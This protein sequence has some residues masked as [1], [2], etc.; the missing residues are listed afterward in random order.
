MQI[1]ST[2]FSDISIFNHEEELSIFHKLDFT[3][4]TGG[5]ETLKDFF[6]KPFNSIEKIEGTHTILR[7]FLEY[8]DKWPID[9]NNGT[10]VMIEKFLDYP[11]NDVPSKPQSI[12][13]FLFTI[14]NKHD[15]E[16]IRF[17]IKHYADFFRG[18]RDL[19][20]LF[21]HTELPRHV[22]QLLL[23]IQKILKEE[24]LYFLSIQEKSKKLSAK[25]NLY[26]ARYLHERYKYY[27]YELIQIFCKFDAWY[28]MAV[29]VK[30][31]NLCFPDFL[32]VDK[33]F[34][35]ARQLYH[36]LLSQ[37]VSYDITMNREQHFIFLTGANMAGK[38]TFIKSLGACVFLA[39]IG[40]GVPAGR[41]QLSLF[42]GLLSNINVVD[43]IVK[44]ESFFFNEVKRIK[45]TIEKINDGGKW[46]VLIDEL[47]K[48]TNV[49]DAMKCSLA[50]IK[51][52]IKIKNSL[53]VLSTHLYEISEELKQY[54]TISFQ[55]FETLIE[56]D[57]LQFSYHLKPGVSNDRI[58][59]IILKREKVTDL[60]D[61]L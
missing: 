35:E 28:S 15:Y 55:H 22:T 24:P 51:G 42:D 19:T 3:Q 60:L 9:I 57:Q 4:T 52:L 47:F 16:L 34:I 56:N 36:M 30:K 21:A 5:R 10:I 11:L 41:L 40:M 33:P 39:H 7:T 18:M 6:S 25:E 53:F 27:T 26:Y 38:S 46:L 59:Y 2:S 58:G 14:F 12:N 49:Q 54:P 29:A 13:S 17:T 44:G 48:G 37:P 20:E 61:S 8:I 23:R 45:N 31:F 43:N 1:D 32:D 50:V